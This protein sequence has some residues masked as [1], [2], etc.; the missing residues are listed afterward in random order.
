MIAQGLCI[1]L[2]EP[3]AAQ[4]WCNDVT[5]RPF[6]PRVK[7]SYALAYPTPQ[8]LSKPISDLIESIKEASKN[9]AF[10]F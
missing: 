9:W 1:G 2:M 3:F 4:H 7:L 5:L 6:R 10:R 8:I